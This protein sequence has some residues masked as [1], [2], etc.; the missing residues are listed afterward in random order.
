[1]QERGAEYKNPASSHVGSQTGDSSIHVFVTVV[2]V[3]AATRPRHLA[4]SW[5]GL[6]LEA[7]WVSMSS[8]H[9]VGAELRN[10]RR[11]PGHRHRH[12]RRC[13]LIHSV[14]L[15]QSMAILSRRLSCYWPSPPSRYDYPLR[16]R[17]T[18]IVSS[19]GSLRG[20]QASTCS[21]PH[22]FPRRHQSLL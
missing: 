15:V 20:T 8:Q 16:S 7:N 21:C 5:I 10:R 13:N 11:A 17:H 18:A 19:Y 14:A 9:V 1:V 12:A 2:H 6:T 3:A 4:C 22:R